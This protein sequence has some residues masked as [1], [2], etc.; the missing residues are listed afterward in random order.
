M[1]NFKVVFQFSQPVS[2]GFNEVYYRQATDLGA[3]SV[4]TPGFLAY[5]TNMRHPLTILQKIRVSDTLNSRNTAVITQ[6]LSGT[7]AAVAEGPDITGVSA[8]VNLNAPQYGATRRLWLRGLTDF[9]VMRNSTS[10]ADTPSSGLTNAIKGWIRVLA[11][12]QFCVRSLFTVTTA[13]YQNQP[14]SAISGAIGSGMVTLTYVGSVNIPLNARILITRTNPKLF[15]SLNGY[16]NVI[17]VGS[18]QFT[19]RYNLDQVPPTELTQGQV[20]LVAYNY[21]VISSS[22]SRFD[23]FGTRTT[24]AGFTPGR[25]RRRGIHLRSL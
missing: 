12:N 2:K 22:T 24:G 20:R 13:G 4:F 17:A 9:D 25:G 18:Q 8:V 5:S 1:A 6:N 3:A 7:S 10:G 19:I 16:W 21:G 11:N 14:L 23:H 15:P